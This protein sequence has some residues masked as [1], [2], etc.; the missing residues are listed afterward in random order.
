MVEFYIANINVYFSC[1]I[2]YIMFT[3]QFDQNNSKNFFEDLY[4]YNGFL[5]QC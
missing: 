4:S 1:H 3:Y 5:I 2:K